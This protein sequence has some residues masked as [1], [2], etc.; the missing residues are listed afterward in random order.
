MKNQ[1]KNI[2]ERGDAIYEDPEEG[3]KTGAIGV[4]ELGETG[5][6]TVAEVSRSHI[7]RG[8][9]NHR[10]ED[11]FPFKKNRTPPKGFKQR[12]DKI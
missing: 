11:K 5:C 2:P 4:P 8:F 7:R 1:E 6:N 3:N 9:L 12:S 10:R